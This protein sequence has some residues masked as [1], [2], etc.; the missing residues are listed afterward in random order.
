MTG[1]EI[2]GVIVAGTIALFMSKCWIGGLFDKWAAYHRAK[3]YAI[4]E[5]SFTP[6]QREAQRIGARLDHEEHTRTRSRNCV[7][8]VKLVGLDESSAYL[9]AAK[10]KK[11]EEA[12]WRFNNDELEKAIAVAKVMAAE[13]E[14][15]SEGAQS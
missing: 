4:R 14:K 1:H 5:A 11:I 9:A 3:E 7:E 6:E 12:L 13:A 2:I 8:V 15:G 10:Q